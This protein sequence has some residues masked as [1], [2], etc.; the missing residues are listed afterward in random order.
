MPVHSFLLQSR[1]IRAEA[2]RGCGPQFC[3]RSFIVLYA[4]LH[5]LQAAE[6]NGYPP[7]DFWAVP[8]SP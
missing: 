3:S 7:G 4:M 8:L 6:T 2:S 5:G 1:V